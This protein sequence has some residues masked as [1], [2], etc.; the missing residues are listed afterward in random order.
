[1]DEA[2]AAV[3]R[4]QGAEEAR[5]ELHRVAVRTDGAA[6]REDDTEPKSLENGTAGLKEG[7]MV[8][9]LVKRGHDGSMT[10][11]RVQNMRT[12]GMDLEKEGGEDSA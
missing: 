3:A 2:K 4:E 8:S 9:M 1:V 10:W 5:Q 7:D 12:E 11:Q 6:V